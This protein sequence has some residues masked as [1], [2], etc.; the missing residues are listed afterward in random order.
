MFWLR[1]NSVFV[2]SDLGID[3][4]LEFRTDELDTE[5]ALRL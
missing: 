4:I 1:W 2:S 3:H 5:S